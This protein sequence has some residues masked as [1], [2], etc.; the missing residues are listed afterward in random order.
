V[1]V[2][3]ID[4]PN[5]SLKREEEIDDGA[6]NAYTSIQKLVSQLEDKNKAVFYYR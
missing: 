4:K 3:S 2:L 6:Y 1:N 5:E